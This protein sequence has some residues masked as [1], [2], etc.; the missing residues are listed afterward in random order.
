LLG[1]GGDSRFGGDLLAAEGDDGGAQ[2]SQGLDD[3]VDGQAG[4]SFTA[5]LRRHGGE[6]LPP[7]PGSAAPRGARCRKPTVRPGGRLR[8]GARPGPPTAAEPGAPRAAAAPTDC[9]STGHAT[10]LLQPPLPELWCT[11]KAADRGTATYSTATSAAVMNCWI[12]LPSRRKPGS[13]GEVVQTQATVNAGDLADFE[14]FFR[15]VKA[16]SDSS[17]GLAASISS[18]PCWGSASCAAAQV[19]AP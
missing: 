18:A 15:H 19:V 2:R 5:P 12:T 11:K 6:G 16:R 9:C 8:T 3:L 4:A 10:H 7:P 14:T 17:S 13:S 1:G